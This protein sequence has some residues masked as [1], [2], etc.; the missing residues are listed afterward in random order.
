MSNSSSKTRT[1]AKDIKAATKE[2]G[3]S[4]NR[5]AAGQGAPSEGEQGGTEGDEESDNTK[6]VHAGED[7]QREI[8]E[9]SKAASKV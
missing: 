3:S 8:E 7:V 6:H 1:K 5:A 4:K 2:G 9:D